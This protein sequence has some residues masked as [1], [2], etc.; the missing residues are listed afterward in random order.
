MNISVKDRM[1]PPAINS[2]FNQEYVLNMRRDY[3]AEI[4]N[5][6]HNFGE[7]LDLI[8]AYGE[9]NNTIIC[10][11]SDHGEMLGDYNLVN[12]Q[13][14]WAGSMNV[15]L[16]CMGPNILGNQ[17]IDWPVT[18]MD[19]AGTFLDYSE[20]KIPENETNVITTK[21]L[22]DVLE[23]RVRYNR[24]YVLSGFNWGNEGEATAQGS[25]RAAIQRENTTLWTTW[26]F[27]CCSISCPGRDFSTKQGNWTY[28]LFNLTNDIYEQENLANDKPMVIQRM[29]KLLPAGFCQDI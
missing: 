3:V 6:D 28:S 18:N 10:V 1:Y 20:S 25:W 27:V 15:P 12:K 8:R 21:S 9:F 2:S 13:V 5:I 16:A 11:S 24:N 26:K 19:L 23:G 14:P 29:K 22:R 17:V 7:I 4:E